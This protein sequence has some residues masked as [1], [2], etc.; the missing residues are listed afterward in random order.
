[1]AVSELE[2][3]N[4]I[5]QLSVTAIK[6]PNY[7]DTK[8]FVS[9]KL[10]ILDIFLKYSTNTTSAVDLL[11]IPVT[12]VAETLGALVNASGSSIVLVK[13]YTSGTVRFISSV[14]AEN[15]VEGEVIFFIE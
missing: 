2:N 12:P 4:A 6:T 13:V 11:Q 3:V 15:Y 1:M 10:A 5:K 8:L 9:G 14:P 7:N